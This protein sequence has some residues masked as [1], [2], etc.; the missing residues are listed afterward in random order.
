MLLTWGVERWR[1]PAPG[2]S[3]ALVASDNPTKSEAIGSQAPSS[4]G[5]QQIS[6]VVPRSVEVKLLPPTLELPSAERWLWWSPTILLIGVALLFGVAA[7]VYREQ[8]VVRDSPDFARALR[9]VKPLLTAINATPRAIKRY[10]N[11]MRYLAARLHPSAHEPDAID[12]LLHWL[13]G[14]IYQKLVPQTWFENKPAP[15]ISEPA[16]ILLGAI[17]MFAPKAFANPAELFVC[18]EHAT[19]GEQSSLDRSAAWSQVRKNFT[20]AQ[21]EMP[22]AAEIARYAEFVL[23]RE[24][25]SLGQPGQVVSFP[26]DQ[27][28]A[29][30]RPA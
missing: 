13:G 21:L 1:E 30:A 16:L 28:Q 2:R 5:K 7:V 29:S 23:I 8:R 14:R 15:A 20:E 6:E 22:T 19:Q 9:S 3:A 11:R 18:L 26:R 24:R 25:P 10:Q 12:S 17:E 4:P 27:T